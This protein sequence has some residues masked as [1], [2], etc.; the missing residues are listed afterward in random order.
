MLPCVSVSADAAT[1]EAY[2][3]YGEPL[4][5]VAD[6]TVV[7]VVDGRPEQVPQTDV[8]GL[9]LD[10]FGGNYL[11]LDIGDGFY[12]FY[13]HVK[14]GTFEVEVGEHVEHGQV[15]GHLG[16]S[17]NSTEPHL[18][19]QMAREPTVFTTTNWP[20]EFTGFDVTGAL[21]LEDRT[22]TDTP[23]SGPK[24]NA[25]PL[26]FEVVT[27]RRRRRPRRALIHSVDG[28]TEPSGCRQPSLAVGTRLHLAVPPGAA[29]PDPIAVRLPGGRTA[30]QCCSATP[31][32]WPGADHPPYRPP[33]RRRRAKAIASSEVQ[34]RPLIP[35]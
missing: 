14:R 20:Y 32:P 24:T 16:N 11:I 27:F 12:A 30:G 31:E 2:L 19:F 18:H 25:L 17:G 4:L 6:G 7:E 9:Q 5:A 26:Q 28:F 21:S 3:A 23:T 15:I 22:V 8:Q 34:I 13:A 35:R 29:P 1:N 33:G 10:E